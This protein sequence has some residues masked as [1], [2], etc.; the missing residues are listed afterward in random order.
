MF[1]WKKWLHHT[2][3]AAEIAD[4][5]VAAAADA[6]AV[7]AAADGEETSGTPRPTPAAQRCSRV[8]SNT[9]HKQKHECISKATQAQKNICDSAHAQEPT[10]LLFEFM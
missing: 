9:Q 4:V 6:T 2:I 10:H 5:A 8:T 3:S 1:R 7:T